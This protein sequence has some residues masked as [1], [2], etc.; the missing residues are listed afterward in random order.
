[1]ARILVI[2]DEPDVRRLL[3]KMLKAA[4]HDV[5]VA[6]DGREGSL[7]VRNAPADLVITDIFMPNQ[8]GFETIMQLRAQYPGLSIIAMSG[9]APDIPFLTIA[10]KLGAIAVLEKPFSSEQLF[11]A[12]ANAL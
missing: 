2:D 12:V 9:K 4:G 5:L 3:E 7:A 6:A 10:E 11:K 8:D 1:M